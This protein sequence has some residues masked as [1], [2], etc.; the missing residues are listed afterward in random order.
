M[1][2]ILNG[3]SSA[4]KSSIQQ[5]FQQLMLPEL[6]LKIGIDSFFD[7]VMPEINT[8]NMHFW[9]SKNPIRWVEEIHDQAGNRIITLMVGP[10]G[11]KVAYAM[12]SAIAEYAKNGCNAI[13]DYIAYNQEWLT[14]LQSKLKDIQTYYVAVQIPLEVLEQREEARGTSPSGHAR[15][16]YHS[17]YSNIHYDLTVNSATH[18]AKEIAQQIKNLVI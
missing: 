3:P 13:V 16:H 2:I 9:Q 7:G 11:E 4:G 17:V 10:E 8:T 6:W 12:N 5:E 14:D 18:G 15:S 1:I